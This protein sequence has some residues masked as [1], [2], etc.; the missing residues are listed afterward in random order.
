MENV[1]DSIKYKNDA[2][3]NK[4]TIEIQNQRDDLDDAKDKSISFLKII[5]VAGT[6]A[7]G[8]GLAA[9]GIAQLVSSLQSTGLFR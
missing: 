3:V 9:Q 5:E 2:I 6:L 4:I 7:A 8:I 1:V